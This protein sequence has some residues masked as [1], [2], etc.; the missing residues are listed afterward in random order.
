[1]GWTAESYQGMVVDARGHGH[2]SCSLGGISAVVIECDRSVSR[3][4]WI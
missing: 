4:M 2:P 1:M 3:S